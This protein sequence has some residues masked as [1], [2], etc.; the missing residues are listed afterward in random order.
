MN[1]RVYK[2]LRKSAAAKPVKIG[3]APSNTTITRM[4]ADKE[5]EDMATMT[6]SIGGGALGAALARGVVLSSRGKNNKIDD[7]PEFDPET[8][9]YI[10]Q[11]YELPKSEADMQRLHKALLGAEWQ[12]GAPKIFRWLLG[13]K[14]DRIHD[15]IRDAIL[16]K[17]VN[18]SGLSKGEIASL[19]FPHILKEDGNMVDSL[20][21]WRM[22]TTP[23]KTSKTL[24]ARPITKEDIEEYLSKAN[25]KKK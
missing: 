11:A 25:K 22:Y 24:G 7:L 19:I 13:P 14:R 16:D 21:F 9:A 23:V 2:A 15:A 17:K 5:N 8:G 12:D 4:F 3:L 18:T 1:N 6:A 10:G 20:G